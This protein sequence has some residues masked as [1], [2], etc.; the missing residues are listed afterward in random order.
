M[1][2]SPI[3]TLASH[4][5]EDFTT[6]KAGFER[7]AGKLAEYGIKVQAVYQAYDNPNMV[8]IQSELPSLAA[9]QAF[10]ADP[11]VRESMKHN[12]VVGTPEIRLLRKHG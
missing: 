1:D 5:V 9:F 10:G 8:Y 2:N 11:A 3:Y 6:W 7:V 4:E 12:G